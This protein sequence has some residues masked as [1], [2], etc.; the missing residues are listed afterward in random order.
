MIIRELTIEQMDRIYNEHIVVDFPLSEV[1]PMSS[2]REGYEH[3]RY[4]AYGMFMGEQPEKLLAYAFFIRS[5]VSDTFLLDYLAV[6]RGNRSN[7]TG[8]LFLHELKKRCREEN[9]KLI[10]EV[11]NPDYAPDEEMAKYRRKRIHFYE[12]NNMCVSDVS[13]NFYNNEYLILYDRDCEYKCP[14]QT[15]I[16]N[17]YRDFFGEKFV[18]ENVVFH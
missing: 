11:E 7:G 3:G 5:T 10:L 1:K 15:E 13:C 16:D 8:S 12:K 6:V 18:D 9:K 14:L 4:F 17:V 2:I